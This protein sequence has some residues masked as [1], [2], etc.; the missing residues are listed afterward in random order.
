M[1]GQL[2]VEAMK[3]HP[4]ARAVDSLEPRTDVNASSPDGRRLK[5]EGNPT[6]IEVDPAQDLGVGI[7]GVD[8][9][10]APRHDLATQLGLGPSLFAAALR[11]EPERCGDIGHHRGV[12][13]DPLK[14]SV[15]KGLAG[16][17]EDS[18]LTTTLDHLGQQ[19]R[20]TGRARRKGYRAHDRMACE[21]WPGRSDRAH[22]HSQAVSGSKPRRAVGSWSHRRSPASRR[23]RIDRRRR[24]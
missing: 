14:A 4:R 13:G 21:P 15:R 18:P 7:V 11:R 6:C 17:L 22:A 19:G 16:D 3:R 1:Q 9:H 24:R 20:Q 23:A 10:H 12:K 2:A 5:R 8:D